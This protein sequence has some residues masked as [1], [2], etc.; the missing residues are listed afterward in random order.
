MQQPD[1]M[2][3]VTFLLEGT[4]PFVRGGVSSWVHD[5][6]TSMPER[7]FSLVFLGAGPRE[8]ATMRYELP[9]NVRALHYFDLMSPDA[10][11]P[12]HKGIKGDPA[13]F[14]AN[15]QLHD[16]FRAPSAA[17]APAVFDAAL[18]QPGRSDATC[19]AEFFHSE[20]AWGQVLEGYQR[21]CPDASLMAYFWSV[22]NTHEPLIRLMRIARALPPTHLV[23]AVSTGYAGFLG[24][25]LQRLH[26]TITLMTMSECAIVHLEFLHAIWVC[27]NFGTTRACV[28]LL[29]NAWW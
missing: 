13:Y 19:A 18:L 1:A 15:A 9:P 29:L 14:A 7:G 16:W 4:Y 28:D 3:D 27:D 11:A 20:A 25:M 17:P 5:L 12:P 8:L 6:I 23:H 10:P 26:H 22:R 21:T 24:A 2:P